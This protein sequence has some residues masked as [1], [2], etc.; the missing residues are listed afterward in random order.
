MM[1]ENHLLQ[2]GV[3]WD[4]YLRELLCHREE[5]LSVM[6]ILFSESVV[7]H[8]VFWVSSFVVLVWVVFVFGFVLLRLWKTP[9]FLLFTC[10]RTT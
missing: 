9:G 2:L 1:R 6:R 8:L 7:F 10:S 5:V 4:I 3:T